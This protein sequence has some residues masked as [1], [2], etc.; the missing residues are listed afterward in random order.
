MLQDYLRDLWAASEEKP[1]LRIASVAL[2]LIASFLS[3]WWMLGFVF[4]FLF[5]DQTVP[6]KVSGQVIVQGKP[7]DVGTL[8]FVS[9]N[10]SETAAVAQ[11][12]NDGFYEL[13]IPKGEYRVAIDAKKVTQ[14]MY[15]DIEKP[16]EKQ[17][18]IAKEKGV[19]LIVGYQETNFLVPNAYRMIQTTPLLIKITDKSTSQDIIIKDAN[20][21]SMLRQRLTEMLAT[22]SAKVFVEKSGKI[23]GPSS[24]SK[25]LSALNK[26]SFTLDDKVSDSEDGPWL[27]ILRSPLFLV[28]DGK[29]K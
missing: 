21:I 24:L 23:I 18:Q 16:S 28:N 4:S 7:I 9:V 22:K 15:P 26:G 11:I 17:I 3:I 25:V 10:Q 6:I 12:E 20:E 2:L 19:D 1:Q 29:Q 14:K 27:P 13:L 8:T 5:P